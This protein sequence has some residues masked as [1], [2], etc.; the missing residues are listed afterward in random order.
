MCLIFFACGD[1]EYLYLALSHLG[2][3]GVYSCF[4]HG[5]VYIIIKPVI[6]VVLTA[7]KK[8]GYPM[9]LDIYKAHDD[10]QMTLR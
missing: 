7:M 9:P 1:M 8:G 6:N 10:V 3:T 4:Y 5:I 2:V